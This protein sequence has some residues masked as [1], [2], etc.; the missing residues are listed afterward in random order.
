ME[1][2]EKGNRENVLQKSKANP[3]QRRPI[4]YI[5]VYFM[6]IRNFEIEM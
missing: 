1:N 6:I 2:E 3:L 4:S 5:C